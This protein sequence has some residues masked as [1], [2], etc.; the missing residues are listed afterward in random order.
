VD[1]KAS[2][3]DRKATERV[4]TRLESGESVDDLAKRMAAGLAGA[5]NERR[6]RKGLPPLT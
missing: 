4:F 1:T 2:D 5:V 3:N 6:A